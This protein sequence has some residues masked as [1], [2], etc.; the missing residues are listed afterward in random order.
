MPRKKGTVNPK[1]TKTNRKNKQRVKSDITQIQAA[2][3]LP[4]S[5]LVRFT[6]FRSYVIVDDGTSG[7]YATV[8]NLQIGANDPT[9]FIATKNGSFNAVSLDAKG[10][11]V[12]NI[13]TWI[14]N[15]SGEGNGMYRTAQCLGARVTITG[16][17]KPYVGDPDGKQDVCK[18]VLHKGS[19]PNHFYNQNVTKDF[20]AETISQ[21]SDV[22][23]CNLYM[24]HN[25]TPRGGTITMNYSFKK[26]NNTYGRQA[27][28]VFYADQSP[29]EKDWFNIV[30]LPGDSHVYGS[31]GTRLPDIRLSVKI[32]YIVLLSEPNNNT[33]GLF[34]NEGLDLPI[35][36]G[37]AG[38]HAN[39]PGRHTLRDVRA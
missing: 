8:P 7:V 3:Y 17:P 14:T 36:P 6:D 20:N 10:A 35:I 30:F 27:Y 21:L 28:N 38:M 11:A 18:M 26:M 31:S 9:K 19:Q 25:G 12:P 32:S 4:K 24:N 13:E 39:V 16:F 5:R 15:Q 22:R 37:R 34:R 23:T 2:S 29:A 33:I 1:N